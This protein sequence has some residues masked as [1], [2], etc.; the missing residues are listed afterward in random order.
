M[1]MIILSTYSVLSHDIVKKV[2]G[3]ELHDTDH[4]PSLALFHILL[5][6]TVQHATWQNTA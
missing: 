2:V 1:E 6:V 3:V 5:R 4:T